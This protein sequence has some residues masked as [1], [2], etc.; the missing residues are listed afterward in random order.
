MRQK[1]INDILYV[2]DTTPYEITQD[3]DA[4]VIKVQEESYAGF[5]TLNESLANKIVKFNYH[6]MTVTKQEWADYINADEP[7]D[8][9]EPSET[10]FVVGNTYHIF[11]D[12][13]AQ[14]FDITISKIDDEFAYG[15]ILASSN[16]YVFDAESTVYCKLPIE[17]AEFIN[18]NQ[19]AENA[20]ILAYYDEREEQEAQWD[21]FMPVIYT[22]ANFV[23]KQNDMNNI[24]IRFGEDTTFECSQEV[25]QALLYDKDNYG[26]A[27]FVFGTYDEP[28]SADPMI[29]DVY[30]EE[31]FIKRIYKDAVDSQNIFFEITAD[32]MITFYNPYNYQLPIICYLVIDVIM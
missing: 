16:Q 11:D 15:D 28:S 26:P 8:P 25:T 5:I 1:K 17:N 6:V 21:E 24:Y 30:D 22:T 14:Y 19:V 2:F 12:D 27:E 7:V 4:D 18:T 13:N 9:D 31:T 29:E 23:Y 20:C 3:T 10:G 32:N